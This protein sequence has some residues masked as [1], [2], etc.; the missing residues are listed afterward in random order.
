MANAQKRDFATLRADFPIFHDKVY[1]NSCSYGALS[2]HVR[3]A[4][5]AYLDA[6]EE[7]GSPWQ[8][9]VE[10]LEQARAQFA[11]QI[12]ASPDEIAITTS[13]SQAIGAI[14]TGVR[15]DQGRDEVLITDY[16]FP[17]SGENWFAQ[18]ARGAR[19]R[20]VG[21]GPS[22]YVLPEDIAAA[23]TD[24]TAVVAATH[25]CYRN[26]FRQ[27]IAAV[28]AAA[29]DAGAI[30]VVDGFQ[31]LGTEALDVKAADLDIYVGGATK[32]MLATA[33]LCFMYVRKPLIE[34]ITPLVSGWFA[35]SDIFAMDHRK[36]DFS[37]TAR[38]FD[39][40]TPPNVNVMAGI[41][42]MDLIDEAG[43]AEIRHHVVGL[44]DRLKA[45][46]RDLQGRFASPDD[47]QWHGAMV[48]IKSTDEN[49]LVAA[50]ESDGIITSCR[51][52]N[53][54]VSAHLYNNQQ[55]ID[56]V[57]AALDKNRSLLA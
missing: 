38:R 9:F 51:D 23:L 40:G 13:A 3:A 12:N 29:R 57:L 55:D 47:P 8:M 54:R 33:G 15:L 6:R 48:A 30:T 18:E 56:A 53:L 22:G 14:A 21:A 35:Q 4:F 2:N 11:G 16:E 27:D 10:K 25:V 45:G 46:V 50:L 20:I 39:S 31:C 32:Y 5:A 52:G 44:N 43:P 19:V 37:S 17:T 34:R 41:A 24:K 26:G 49:A 28:T 42:G 7:E 36:N 1:I